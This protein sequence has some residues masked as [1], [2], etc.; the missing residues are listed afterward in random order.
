MLAAGHSV[1]PLW[2]R[3]LVFFFS[4]PNLRDRLA[5]RHQTLARSTVTQI[6]EIRS[7]ICVAP[8]ARNLAAQKHQN[9]RAILHN[10]AT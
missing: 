6:Y 10:F 5:D 2:F 9:F 3:S 8:S 4:P 1:L 7:E